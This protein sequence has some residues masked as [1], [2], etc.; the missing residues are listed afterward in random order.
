MKLIIVSNRLPIKLKEN[1][2]EYEYTKS[3]GGLA[4]GIDNLANKRDFIWVGNLSGYDLTENEQKR[5]SGDIWT[6]FKYVPIF[7]PNDTQSKFYNGFCNGILWPLLHSF[8][9]DVCF[10]FSDHRAYIEANEV[11]ADKILEVADEDSTIWVHDYH[12]FYLPEILKRKNPKLKVAFFLHV[13]FPVYDNFA[14]LPC[15]KQLVKSIAYADIVAFHVPEY[16]IN[17]LE[18]I[19][20]FEIDKRPITKAISIGIDP[21]QFRKTCEEESTI[22]F[23]NEIKEK[24]KDKKII[25]EIDRTDY[26]KGF[27]EKY[28]AI[29]RFYKKYPEYVKK[30]VFLQ[31]AIPSRMDVREY[32]CYV[33]DFNAQ[34]QAINGKIGDLHHTPVKLQFS[35]VSFNELCALYLA[36]DALFVGSIIDGMNLVALEYVACQDKNKGV[37]ILSQNIGALISLPG[38]VPYNPCNT[39]DGADTIKEALELTE[40]NKSERHEF[41][42]EMI[43]KFTTFKWAEDNLKFIEETF[44]VKNE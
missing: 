17:F 18:N 24:Y 1:D 13:P 40:E 19:K 32:S 8:C 9:D 33:K 30:V 21:N 42:K 35:S 36:G 39:E 38:A 43:D 29:E 26:I 23:Y 6:K 37:L 12:L 14:I 15:S 25:I 27:P 11:F 44:E 28:K 7:L 41:N 22:K 4:A 2:G 5:I 10:T 3:S 16:V 31:V 20:K 34:V